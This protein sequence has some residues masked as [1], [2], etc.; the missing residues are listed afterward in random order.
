M[1]ALSVVSVLAS[2]AAAGLAVYRFSRTRRT[3][4]AAAVPDMRRISTEGVM[5]VLITIVVLAA[6]LYVILSRS[7]SGESEKWAFG[8]VGL[9]LGFWL[10][11]KS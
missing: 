9:V 5:R 1:D 7:Y 11:G 10:P 2:L 8:V 4:L 3:L 6:A